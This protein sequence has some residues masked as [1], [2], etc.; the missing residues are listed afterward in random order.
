M[1]KLGYFLVAAFLPIVGAEA[2]KFL[3][4]QGAPEW[5]V[6]GGALFVALTFS[7]HVA[8]RVTFGRGW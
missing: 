8:C 7:H 6:V 2:V 5:L 1:V 3:L 4:S